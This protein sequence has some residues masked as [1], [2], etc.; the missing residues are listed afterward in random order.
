MYN[1]KLDKVIKCQYSNVKYVPLFKE[2]EK[3]YESS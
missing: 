2:T 1:L 3:E